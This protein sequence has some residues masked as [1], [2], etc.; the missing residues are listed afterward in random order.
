MLTVYEEEEMVM[1]SSVMAGLY[2][3]AQLVEDMAY[4]MVVRM[5]D[6]ILDRS[7]GILVEGCD[8][9]EIIDR[10]GSTNQNACFIDYN[11][12]LCFVLLL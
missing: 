3:K 1:I 10:D 7:T 9:D 12:Y 2:V 5:A 8:P 6:N 11:T 4:M